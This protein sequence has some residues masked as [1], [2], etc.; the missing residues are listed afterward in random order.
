MNHRSHQIDGAGSRPSDDFLLASVGSTP[1][2]S[3]LF[4]GEGRRRER[5]AR[6]SRR[7]HEKA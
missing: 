1:G 7:H 6:R 3:A 2:A 5:I 4:L